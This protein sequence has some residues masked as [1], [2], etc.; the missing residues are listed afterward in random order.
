MDENGKVRL[1]K[2]IIIHS[3]GSPI[4]FGMRATVLDN[5]DT[6]DSFPVTNVVEQGSVL[7]PTLFSM[8]V[9]TMLHDTSQDNDDGIQLKYRTD[10]GVCNLRRLKETQR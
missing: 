3:T 7:S 5:C 9:A 8:V 4:T 1:P 10:G 6:S 2:K